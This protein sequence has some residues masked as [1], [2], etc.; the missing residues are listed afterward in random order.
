MILF[1]DTE[2]NGLPVNLNEEFNKLIVWPNMVQIAWSLCDTAG[3]QI[4]RECHIIKPLDFEINPESTLIHGIDNSTAQNIGRDLKEVINELLHD[5]SRCKTI[6]F[7]NSDF[8]LNVLKN[9]LRKVGLGETQLRNRRIICTMKCSIDY[10]NLRNDKGLKF[11]KLDELYEKLYNAKIIPQHNA[12]F[13]LT[14]L[15]YC[16]FKLLK[17]QKIK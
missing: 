1:I 10:C 9:E 11:P 15:E 17:L 14:I 6:V 4:K 5:I 7:H 13:D 3:K 16:F 12:L 2:T 8:D